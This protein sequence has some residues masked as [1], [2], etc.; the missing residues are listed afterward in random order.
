MVSEL[1]LSQ[2]P[3]QSNPS[4]YA[5][6]DTLWITAGKLDDPGIPTASSAGVVGLMT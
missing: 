4:E 1:D 6:I 2:L 3:L 5:S